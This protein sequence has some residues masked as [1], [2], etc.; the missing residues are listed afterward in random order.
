MVEMADGGRGVAHRRTRLG[1]NALQP[2]SEQQRQVL[3]R[4]TRLADRVVHDHLRRADGRG[5][6]CGEQSAAV[7]DV[8]RQH[9]LKV[10]LDTGRTHQ[11]RVHM[12][13]LRH[14]VFGDPVY[15]GRLQ[16]PAGASETLREVLR[17]FKR[18]ALHAKRLQLKH[19]VMWMDNLVTAFGEGIDRIYEFGGGIGPGAP[20]E[21]RPN[22]ESMIKKAA[23]TAGSEAVYTPAINKAT[24]DAI[25]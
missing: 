6:E 5:I 16:L 2:I 10:I 15:G 19:P 4:L 8:A 25:N 13:H 7:V 14:P 22:L 18:Q 3:D 17:G 12:A 23:R 9:L 24:L 1:R 11:I 20:E 21:K